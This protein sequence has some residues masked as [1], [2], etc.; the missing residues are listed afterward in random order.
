MIAPNRLDAVDTDDVID[1]LRRGFNKRNIALVTAAMLD[2]PDAVDQGDATF[3]CA[4]GFLLDLNEQ[5][6]GDWLMDPPFEF[7]R[8]WCLLNQRLQEHLS[9]PVESETTP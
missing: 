6:L 7:A 4:L 9:A 3:M 5:L 2:L 8:A 1:R